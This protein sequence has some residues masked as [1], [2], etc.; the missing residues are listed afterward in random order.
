MSNEHTTR[1]PAALLTSISLGFIMLL[2]WFAWEATT[3]VPGTNSEFGRWILSSVSLF[4]SGIFF[5]IAVCK[6]HFRRQKTD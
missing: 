5:G 2:S 6:I 1:S 4:L 3:V